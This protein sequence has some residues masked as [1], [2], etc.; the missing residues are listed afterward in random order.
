M[1]PRAGLEGGKSRPHRDC[2]A[3]SHSLYRLS[4]S[5]YNNNN[6]KKKKKKK[7]KKNN[8]NIVLSEYEFMQVKTSY[9]VCSMIVVLITVHSSKQREVCI[10]HGSLY[11]GARSV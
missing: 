1:D 3:R 5:A 6:N 4:Y 11:Q 7:K 2:R 9:D 10:M 8:N